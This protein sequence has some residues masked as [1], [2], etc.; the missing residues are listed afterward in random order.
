MIRVSA[1]TEASGV[2]IV[3]QTYCFVVELLDPQGNVL[4]SPWEGVD[5][6]DLET[7]TVIAQ[8][9]VWQRHGAQNGLY[10]LESVRPRFRYAYG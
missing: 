7:A 2:R 1:R 4:A 3:K 10:P 6:S 5:A 9:R 8:Q